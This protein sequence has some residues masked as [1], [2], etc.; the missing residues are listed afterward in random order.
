VLLVA[1][2]W[3][4][5]PAVPQPAQQTGRGAGHR[6]PEREQELRFV[7]DLTGALRAWLPT[8]GSSSAST[9]PGR[10]AIVGCWPDGEVTRLQVDD[11]RVG[12]ASSLI[13]LAMT[14]VRGQSTVAD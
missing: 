2:H 4:L 14:Y 3:L 5:H 1:P 12:Q 10:Q 13:R 11:L 7:G 9:R 6:P 8:P